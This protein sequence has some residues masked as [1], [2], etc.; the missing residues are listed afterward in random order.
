M[1]G[2]KRKLMQEVT[3]SSAI[4]T[5]RFELHLTF[6]MFLTIWLSRLIT[7]F[8]WIIKYLP[9]FEKKCVTEAGVF[10]A[11]KLQ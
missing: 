8:S 4:G 9:T 6:S 3:S 11:Q 1:V 10:F 2:I 5:E 7:R